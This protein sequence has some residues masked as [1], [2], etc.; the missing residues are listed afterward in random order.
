MRVLIQIGSVHNVSILMLFECC[1]LPKQDSHLFQKISHLLSIVL[2]RTK[3]IQM[4]GDAQKELSKFLAFHLFFVSQ[5]QYIQSFDI[6]Q[7]FKEWYNMINPHLEDCFPSNYSCVE[8]NS[9]SLHPN[10]SDMHLSSLSEQYDYTTCTCLHRPYKN[11]NVAWSLET[12]I[13]YTSQEFLDK[14]H[15][16]SSG[17]VGIDSLFNSHISQKVPT[18]KYGVEELM[19]QAGDDQLIQYAARD[20]LSVTKI[21]IAVRQRWSRALLKKYSSTKSIHTNYSDAHEN[22]YCSIQQSSSNEIILSQQIKNS[23]D[24][25]YIIED[26]ESISDD[27]IDNII[28]PVVVPISDIIN[29]ESGTKIIHIINVEHEKK[30]SREAIRRR[31]RKRNIIIHAHRHDFDVIRTIYRCFTI[32]EIENILNHLDI[33]HRHCHIRRHYQLHIGLRSYEDKLKYEHILNREYFTKEHYIR[34]LNYAS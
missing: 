6:Q 32:R 10:S 15:K 14:Q 7:L 33:K 26:Y 17:D 9:I 16:L 27:D 29:H 11:P 2:D 20:C 30:R 24:Y 5:I 19:Q 22:K 31:C 34:E 18:W 1:S 13:A 28:N 12:A 4:R 23:N 25:T 3:Q 21:A 8:D